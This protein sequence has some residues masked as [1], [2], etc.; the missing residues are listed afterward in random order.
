MSLRSAAAL[1]VLAS[2]TPGAS[3]MPG[4][5]G[6][7]A[8]T[9]DVNLTLHKDGYAPDVIDAPVGTT[10]RFSN[11]DGFP[12]TATLI[13]GATSFPAGSP[14]GASAQVQSGTRISQPWSTGSMAAGAGS[15]SIVLDA[16]GTYL[17]GCFYHYGAPMRGTIV[18][19]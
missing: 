4:A 9:I 17:Y 12:H 2:C 14:F 3:G 15:Q 19:H 13:P 5:A 1:L 18:V 7:A 16:P 8:Q 6:A 10:L 11:S